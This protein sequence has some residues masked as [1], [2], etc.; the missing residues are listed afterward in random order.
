MTY[1]GDVTVGSAPAVREL[2]GLTVTKVAV[3]THNNNAYLLRCGSD[4]S[5]LLI[6]AAS[7]APVL[8]GLIG[9][10]GLT[11]VVTT[12]QHWDHHG[13][14]AE[15]VKATGARSIAGTDDAAAIP[16]VTETVND[17]DTITVGDCTL[18]V[19]HV[20][21][22]TPGSIVLLYREPGGIAHLFTGDSLFPGGVGATGGDKAK[23]TSLINDVSAK[24]FDRLPDDTWFYPG[25]GNDSTLGAER[26]SLPEWRARGW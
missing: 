6:D 8:L 4:G 7:E 17:G 1:T 9:D 3:G 2:N 18:E 11:T 15:I 22:H 24:L 25:H 26:P 10:A 20:V 5:Q 13:A 21:G 19:I 16:V 12:H 14:L 23:F